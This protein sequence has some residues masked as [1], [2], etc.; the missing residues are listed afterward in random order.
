MVA[1]RKNATLAEGNQ[2]TATAV[3]LAY[4]DSMPLGFRPLAALPEEAE[5]LR[6]NSENLQILALDAALEE[7]H[8]VDPKD[9]DAVM[10]HELERLESKLN[11]IMQLLS[12]LLARENAA[13]VERKF[14]LAGDGIAW[15][16]DV[17]LKL[18][19]IGVVSLHINRS[20]PYPLELVGRVVGCQQT[21]AIYRVAFAFEGVAAN[22][23]ELL[24]KMIFRHHRRAVADARSAHRN[25]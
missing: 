1:P 5:L 8:P 13:P 16:H 10:R 11:I 25:A 18:E 9:D 14:R 6:I 3:G 20:L 15:D 2:A 21:G 24:E 19:S 17:P 23:I 22:V 7:R 4:H 12:R